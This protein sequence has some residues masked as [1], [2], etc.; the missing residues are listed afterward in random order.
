MN[1]RSFFTQNSTKSCQFSLWFRTIHC[2]DPISIVIYSLEVDINLLS[3]VKVHA[4]IR[5]GPAAEAVY[6][7]MSCLNYS[8]KHTR[9][10]PPKV[11]VT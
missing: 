3:P 1:E 2:S 5:T 10:D 8:L 6:F 9:L 11:I 7:F 4:Q